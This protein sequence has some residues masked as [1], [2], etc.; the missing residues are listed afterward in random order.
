VTINQIRTF[1]I[2]QGIAVRAGASALRKSL[3]CHIGELQGRDIA[4][5]GQADLWSLQRLALPRTNL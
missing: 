3:F 5:N 2:E 4:Q 1:L